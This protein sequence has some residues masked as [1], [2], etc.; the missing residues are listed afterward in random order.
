MILEVKQL[1]ASYGSVQILFG[2]DIQV[3]AGEIVCLL[4]RNGVGKTTTLNAI[5]GMVKP[6]AGIIKFN[7][8]DISTMPP[9]RIARLG[10][11][12]APQGR[13][14]FPNLTTRENLLISIRKGDN[15][16]GEWTLERIYKL[17]PRLE[18]RGNNKCIKL[19]GGE[20]QMV[21]IARALIQNPKLLIMDEIFEGLAPIIVNE[22][23]DVVR[24]LKLSCISI[25]FAEHS[26]KYVREIGGSC[27]IL[28]KGQVVFS[29]P[30][31]EIPQDVVLK[32]LGA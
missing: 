29:G 31:L 32:Y 14:I 1:T 11:A 27:N 30:A 4:G 23:M 15:H 26:I 22:I 21:C 10:I 9:Y 20:L 6:H 5:L 7:N 18:E 25:L 19:S 17:F 16:E 3:N 12:Y 28:E 8:I 13:H 2:V 24:Q